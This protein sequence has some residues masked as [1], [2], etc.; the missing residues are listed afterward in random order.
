MK[1]LKNNTKKTSAS[2]LSSLFLTVA[3]AQP[4]QSAVLSPAQQVQK[5]VNWFTGFFTNAEQVANNEMIP[6]LTME[7]CRASVSGGSNPDAQYVHLEQYFGGVSILRTAAYEFSPSDTGVNLSVFPY[8]EDDNA[9]GTCN[10]DNPIIDL[11][12]LPEVS[13]DLNLMYEPKKFNGTN[14][15]DGC[16]TT[17]PVENSMVVSTVMI[18]R[19]ATD[20]LDFFIPPE[21]SNREPF[22]SLIEFR[23]VATT[24]EPMSIMTLL[25]IGLFGL[26]K[27]RKL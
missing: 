19:N 25:G 17:F 15:P 26:V 8:L 22:G 3:F 9:L 10:S 20:S 11:S 5:V 4:G 12:N 27:V 23:Q 2:F 1:A 6:F 13:C 16:P 7:N 24:S 21:E 18:S 14:A